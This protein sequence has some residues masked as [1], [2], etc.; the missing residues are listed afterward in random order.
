MKILGVFKAMRLSWIVTHKLIL[1]IIVVLLASTVMY[2]YYFMVVLVLK[3]DVVTIGEPILE[4][5]VTVKV[6]PEIVTINESAQ[7]K[8]AKELGE[9]IIEIQESQK[10]NSLDVP[11]SE[12]TSILFPCLMVLLVVIN[13][14]IGLYV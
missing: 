10:D 13:I 2:Y 12:S 7:A 8:Q 6:G 5:P 1:I 11:E 3:I 4:L 14:G 9:Q